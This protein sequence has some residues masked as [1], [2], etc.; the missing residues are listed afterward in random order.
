MSNKKI[1]IYI[2]NINSIL[3]NFIVFAVLINSILIH[4]ITYKLMKQNYNNY[5]VYEK[6]KK[7][8]T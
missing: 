4:P 8:V 2:L 1:I 5:L 3:N 7:E 6:M